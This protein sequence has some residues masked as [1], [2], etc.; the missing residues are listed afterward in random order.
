M[1]ILPFSFVLLLPAASVAE[2]VGHWTL[3]EGTGTTTADSSPNGNAGT[4]SAGAT[5]TTI[6]PTSTLSGTKASQ[7]QETGRLPPGSKPESIAPSKTKGLSL[8]DPM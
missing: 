6:M 5:W 1:K 4:I 2:L 7:G 3:E 8:G